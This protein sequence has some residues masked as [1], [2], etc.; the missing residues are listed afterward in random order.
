MEYS[1]I[2]DLVVD[3]ISESGDYPT[4]RYSKAVTV[5]LDHTTVSQLDL[6]VEFLTYGSRQQL[7]A[8]LLHTAVSDAISSTHQ[9][10]EEHD[11]DIA[12]DFMVR[13]SDILA[14][15]LG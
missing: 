5:R 15:R 6:L 1:S 13:V 11:H 9:T 14:D 2:S 4:D 3:R 7:M 12:R 8:D 10:L